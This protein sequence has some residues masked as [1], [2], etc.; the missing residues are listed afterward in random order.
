VSNFDIKFMPS[1]RGKAQC[2]P[3]PDFPGGKEIPTPSGFGCWVD[4]PYPAPECGAYAVR[5]HQCGSSCA[6]TSVGRPDDPK[7]FQMMCKIN[8]EN[9]Q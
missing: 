3:N 2:P 5:C 9:T 6:I 1:G 4:L 7:R 8:K